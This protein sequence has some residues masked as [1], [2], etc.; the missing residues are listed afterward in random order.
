MSLLEVYVII[1]YYNQAEKSTRY[2]HKITKQQFNTD[3]LKKEIK[4]LLSYQSDALHWN[5]EH[6][7]NVDKI[8]NEVLKCYQNIS[9]KL[10]VRM[11]SYDKAKQRIEQLLKGKNEFINLSRKLAQQVQQR[12]V[13][14]TQPKEFVDGSKALLTINNY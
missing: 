8:G 1:A 12:E 2:E 9:T 11:H 14:I 5:L 13:V 7:N 4:K 10:N 6:L 3:Y